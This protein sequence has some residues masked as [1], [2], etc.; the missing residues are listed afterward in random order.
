MSTDQLSFEEA[1]KKLEEIV[2]KLESNVLTLDESVN[3]YKEGFEL[4]LLC[5]RLLKEAE[6]KI[7]VISEKIN[8]DVLL[9][10]VPRTDF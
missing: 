5:D 8:G 4:S 1:S 10:E 7:S 9:K 6:E 3:L 2:Q